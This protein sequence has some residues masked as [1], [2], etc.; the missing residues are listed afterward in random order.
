MG[1]ERVLV[2]Q[3][4]VNG[5]TIPEG[6]ETGRVRYSIATLG[7]LHRRRTSVGNHES[8]AVGQD[9]GIGRGGVRDRNVVQFVHLIVF[10]NGIHR[11]LLRSA[12]IPGAGS[13]SQCTVP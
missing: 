6:N 10:G 8:G 9:E 7:L 4:E 13:P 2:G 12:T 11:S 3:A 5:K 1:S